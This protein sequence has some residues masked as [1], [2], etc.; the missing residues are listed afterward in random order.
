MNQELMGFLQLADNG[1]LLGAGCLTQA[2]FHA[3]GS[4][5]IIPDHE[6]TVMVSRTLLIIIHGSL[7]YKAENTR[8]MNTLGAGQAI[9]AACAGDYRLFQVYLPHLGY[10]G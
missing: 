2:A 3:M 7:I 8:D 5:G 9:L 1:Y 4:I 6:I 10:K